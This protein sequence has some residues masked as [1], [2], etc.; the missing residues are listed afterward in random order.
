MGGKK[1]TYDDPVSNPAA[2]QTQTKSIGIAPSPSNME[3]K[4]L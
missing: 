4:L 3:N 1:I 2:D